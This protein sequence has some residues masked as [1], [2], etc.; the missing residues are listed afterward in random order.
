MSEFKGS[1]KV[2]CIDCVNLQDRFCSAKDTTVAP[3]KKRVCGSYEFTGIYQNRTPLPVSPV[4]YVDKST[5]RMIKKLLSLGILQV[6][7]DGTVSAKQQIE[8]PQSTA[9]AAVL[10]MKAMED[11]SVGGA[12][13]TTQGPASQIPFVEPGREVIPEDGPDSNRNG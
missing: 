3:R 1:S 11:F 5:R 6:R 8:V 7:P 10:G 2:R 13:M 9:T 4:P 12:A